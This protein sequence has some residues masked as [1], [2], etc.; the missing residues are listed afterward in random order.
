MSLTRDEKIEKLV[1]DQ[2]NW[3]T[4]NSRGS[5]ADSIRESLKELSN[6]ELDFALGMRGIKFKD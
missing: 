6:E 5:D 3:D 1:Q 2:I 4:E